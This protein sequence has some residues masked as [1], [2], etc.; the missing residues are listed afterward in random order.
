MITPWWPLAILAAI[1]LADAAMCWKP[2]RFIADCLTDVRFPQRY[3]WML[4]PI[5]VAAAGR[6]LF[7]NASGMLVLSTAALVYVAVQ[8]P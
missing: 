2:V 6:N 3:W 7:V 8:L 4:T 5:K 1:Q